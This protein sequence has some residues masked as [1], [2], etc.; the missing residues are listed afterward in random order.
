[1]P[2]HLLT[3]EYVSCDKTPNILNNILFMVNCSVC[4]H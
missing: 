2:K 3:S 1:M 4:L